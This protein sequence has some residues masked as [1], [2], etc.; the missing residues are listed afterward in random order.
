MIC[1][2]FTGQPV[3]GGYI[4]AGVFIGA[5]L[6]YFLYYENSYTIW[7]ISALYNKGYHS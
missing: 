7:I 6:F 4:K 3:K 2:P 5:I 1:P